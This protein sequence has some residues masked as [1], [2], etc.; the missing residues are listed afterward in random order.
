MAQEKLSGLSL[1]SIG[2]QR[3]RRKDFHIA[4]DEFASMKSRKK[5]V[6]RRSNDKLL[7]DFTLKI[8]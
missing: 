4:I 8:L 3:V 2:T 7:S 1:L 5:K 6:H